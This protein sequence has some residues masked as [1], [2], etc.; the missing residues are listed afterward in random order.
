MAQQQLHAIVRGRVQGVGF[1]Y[2]VLQRAQLLGLR[3]WVA[4]REDRSVE[5]RAEGERDT[6]DILLAFLHTGP[7]HARVDTVESSW[8]EATG[9]FETF[10]VTG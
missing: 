2:S 9:A 8:H 4:N 3:G 6:L 7:L 1:R 5:L 10:E